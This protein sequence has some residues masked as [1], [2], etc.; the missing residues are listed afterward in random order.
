M[1]ARRELWQRIFY[2]ALLIAVSAALVMLGAVALRTVLQLERARKQTLIDATL[3]LA[4]ERAAR[5]DKRII[6]Q[7]NVMIAHVD[8]GK[9]SLLA[10]RWLATASRETPTVR[11]LVMLNLSQNDRPIV[12]FVSRAPGVEDDRFRRMLVYELLPEFDLGSNPE[13]LKHLQY[14]E[15]PQS[16]L[17]SYWQR[18]IGRDRMLVVAWHDVPRVVHD[19]MPE[20]YPDLERGGNRMNV[21]DEEGRIVFGPPIGVGEFTVG[22]PF[23]TTLYAWRLQLALTSAEGLKREADRKRELEV[24][25]VLLSALIAIAGTGILLAASLKQARLSDLKNQFVA[26]VSHELKTPLSLIRM[27]SELLLSGRATT[28]DKRREYTQII[29]TESERLT[30]LIENVLDFARVEQGKTAFSFARCSL[31]DVVSRSIEAYRYR[32]EREG[33]ALSVRLPAS[34]PDAW[35]DARAV[36]LALMNLIDNAIKYARDGQRIE[37]TVRHDERWLFLEVT[38]FGPG[39]GP[40]DQEKIF[41]RFFR[42]RHEGHA[43]IRGSGIGLSLVRDIARGH[44]GSVRVTSPG[45]SGTGCVM[46]LQLPVFR[47]GG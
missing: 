30:A 11:A 5:P 37:V 36:E 9:P 33:M 2:L 34:L 39:I 7:D 18:T 13:E 38:D 46:C 45:P 21:I 19:L 16:V 31:G 27:F 3:S 1:S 41:D 40:G 12:N 47:G 35:I 32:A 15:G 43:H 25:I 44:G 8:D 24:A 14:V 17:V 28:D 23:P 42:G 26:N 29:Q 22:K 6:A 20:L 4:D 10:D